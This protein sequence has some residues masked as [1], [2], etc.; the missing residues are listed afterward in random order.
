MLDIEQPTRLRAVHDFVDRVGLV[1]GLVRWLKG[2]YLAE[3]RWEYVGLLRRGL[4]TKMGDSEE[5]FERER[6]CVCVWETNVMAKNEKG[7]K[8]RGKI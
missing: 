5:I 7:P 4:E 2:T 3:K 8:N 6:E 1:G